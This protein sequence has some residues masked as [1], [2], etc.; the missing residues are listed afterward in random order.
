MDPPQ[1]DMGTTSKAASK[2][3]PPDPKVAAKLAEQ[4]KRAEDDAKWEKRVA[5]YHPQHV[6]RCTQ[7]LG[8]L[9]KKEEGAKAKKAETHETPMQLRYAENE[10]RKFG[11]LAEV[12]GYTYCILCCK[13]ADSMHLQAVQHK[14]PLSWWQSLSVIGGYREL[15]GL[16]SRAEEAANLGVKPDQPWLVLQHPSL[17]KHEDAEARGGMQNASSSVGPQQKQDDD[18]D[19]DDDGSGLA[20]A[21]AEGCGGESD[22]VMR[23]ATKE[24][25]SPS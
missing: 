24:T 5:P 20:C 1:E 21:A 17:V 25:S 10:E 7:V 11:L 9:K 8:Q 14:K 16:Q 2:A 12:Q 3:V 13:W 22:L 18:D 4:K 15:P 6:V 23:V 19:D